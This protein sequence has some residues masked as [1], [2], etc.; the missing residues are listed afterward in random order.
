MNRRAFTDRRTIAYEGVALLALEFQ[1]LRLLAHRRKLKHSAVLPERRPA[2]NNRVRSDYRT[3]SNLDV[4]AYHAI[5][6]D[7]DPV[8]YARARRYHR[9]R[10]YICSH[11]TPCF[12][13]HQTHSSGIVGSHFSYSPKEPRDFRVRLSAPSDR[14]NR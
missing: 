11:F 8:G 7:F 13:Y 12:H 1:I 10:M 9:A 4:L 6:S 2:M 3:R 5:R 14:L